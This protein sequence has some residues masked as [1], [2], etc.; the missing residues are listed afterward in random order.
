MKRIFTILILSLQFSL[1]FSQD[2]R[3]SVEPIF[4]MKYGEVDEYVFLKNCIYSDDKLSELNWDIKPE[5]YAG[6]KTDFGY[7]KILGEMEVSFGFH[8]RIGNMV[9]SDWFNAQIKNASSYQYKTNF[10]ESDNYLK[11]DFTFGASAGYLF[12]VYKGE[13]LKFGVKPK[14]AFEF[15]NLYF[16]GRNGLAWYGKK[17]DGVYQHYETATTP[18]YDFSGNSV[19]DYSREKYVVWLG[20]DV[21]LELPINFSLD[22]GFLV[23]PYTYAESIDIHYLNDKGKGTAYLDATSGYFKTFKWNVGASYKIN[24]RN[25]IKLSSSW[26]YM[27]VLRGINYSKSYESYLKSN[28]FDAVNEKSKFVDGGAAEHYWNLALSWNFRIF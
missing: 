27:P 1:I 23:S 13:K 15:E 16:N 3:L 4:G 14:V 12:D 11:R 8:M 26:F 18:T 22:A 7:K 20:F 9:D 10:S 17:V 2:W 6:L 28:K 21:A 24:S 19:I 5:L 25:S